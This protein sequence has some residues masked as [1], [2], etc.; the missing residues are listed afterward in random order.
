MFKKS[1]IFSKKSKTLF[2]FKITFICRKL[3]PKLVSRRSESTP[4]VY[5]AQNA[6]KFNP[7]LLARLRVKLYK[8]GVCP[9]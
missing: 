3:I 8:N 2:C 5:E 4:C 7:T 1:A 9:K 6:P